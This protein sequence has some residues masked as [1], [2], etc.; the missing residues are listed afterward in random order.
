MREYELRAS[1][2]QLKGRTLEGVDMSCPT[3]WIPADF[4]LFI[5]L[6]L[7]PW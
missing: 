1:E 6:T 5:S 4:N 3:V 7:I 2:R